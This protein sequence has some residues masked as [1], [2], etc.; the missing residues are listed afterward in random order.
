MGRYKDKLMRDSPKL[1]P[2]DS[3][4]FND[5]VEGIGMDVVATRSMEREVKYS[6]GLPDNIWRTMN[7]VWEITLTSCRII[8][9]IDRFSKAIDGIIEAE[10]NYVEDYYGTHG[11][12][13]ATQKPMSRGP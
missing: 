13:R 11:H 5:L 2:L 10:G 1:M 12:Q 6:V 4:F 7:A 9:D 8:Q 3:S